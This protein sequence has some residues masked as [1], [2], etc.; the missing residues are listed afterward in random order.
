MIKVLIADDHPIVLSGIRQEL[1]PEVG[2]QLVEMARNSTELLRLL[3]TMP[4]DV[5]VTD[6]AMPGGEI[7]DGLLTSGFELYQYA[8][9]HGLLPGG[10]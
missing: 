2:M 3:E 4:C 1:S 9:E 5:I 8:V 6:Y 10:Q 7:G